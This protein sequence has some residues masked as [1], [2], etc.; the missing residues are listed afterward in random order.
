[1]SLA[2][3]TAE[4]GERNNSR[5]DDRLLYGVTK[6]AGLVPM[7]ERV[8]GDST[9]RCKVVKPQAFAYNPMRVNIGSIARNSTSRAVMVSP[10]YVVFQTNQDRLLPEYLDHLRRSHLWHSFVSAA[11]DGSVRVRIYYDHLSQLRFSLP[12]PAEQQR[13]AAIL[14]TVN[15]KLDVIARQIE[16]THTLKQGLMRT[17]FNAGVGT[18]DA[19][20]RWAPHAEFK[21]S[22]LGRIPSAWE[23]AAVGEVCDVRGGKRLPKGES[24]VAE[25]TG[26]P[27]IRVSD[28]HMGGVDTSNILF[29]PAH[30]QPSIARYTISKDDIFISVAGTLGIV[31]VIP[32]ELDG[33]NLTENADKLTDIK[34]NRDYLFHCL[35]SE[36]IQQA[37]AREATSNAQPKLAL[38]KIREFR[39]PLPPPAEQHR[40]AAVL[41]VVDDKRRVLLSKQRHYQSLTRGLMQKLLTGVWRVKVDAEMAT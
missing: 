38:S 36:P 40:I 29:V 21:E 31:G 5:L 37:I 9:S 28:M 7:K 34:V 1:M 27:Y 6:A 3:V 33:A 2:E 4:C 39:F 26:Y 10:D 41:A 12:P 19:E 25:N 20:G 35:C 23:V 8:K 30:L 16:A 18:Q 11:G 13:I 24:L 17:L 15:D 14:A 32:D 22:E